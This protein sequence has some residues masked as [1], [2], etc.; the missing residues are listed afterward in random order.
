MTIFS[1]EQSVVFNQV[2]YTSKKIRE[3]AV[4]IKVAGF[5]FEVIRI[6]RD[7][8]TVPMV[9]PVEKVVLMNATVQ[10]E[11]EVYELVRR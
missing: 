11:I 1:T 4:V 9:H 5:P 6:Q 8:K 2:R 10:H 3:T 7:L